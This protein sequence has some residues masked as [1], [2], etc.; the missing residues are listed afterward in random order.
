M[1]NFFGSK[2]NSVLLIILILLMV[3]ALKVML[4]DKAKY[5]P[6]LDQS[7]NTQI[8]GNKD[9]LVSF[10]ILPGSRVHGVTSYQGVV[11][12]AYFF[13]ANIGIAITDTNKKVILQDHANA[14]TDWMTSGPVSFGGSIDVSG[15]PKGDAYLV[16]QADNPSDM[17]E[18]DK[19]IFIPIV[20]E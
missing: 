11:K 5:L 4:N 9:D 20:I 17:R 19:F 1:S 13:E 6:F 7:Q 8:L 3:V 16:I 2:L 18:N 15:L 10:S 12:G 14:T